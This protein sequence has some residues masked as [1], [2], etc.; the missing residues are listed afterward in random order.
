M[1][2]K[3]SSDPALA[4][5]LKINFELF[6][7]ISQPVFCGVQVN[8]TLS[9]YKFFDALKFLGVGGWSGSVTGGTDNKF[10][11]I[12]ADGIFFE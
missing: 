1:L 12:F 11:A 5:K 10:L 7:Q 3:S 8:K 4:L 9:E 2:E 6:F